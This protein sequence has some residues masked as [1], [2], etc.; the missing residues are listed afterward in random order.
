MR[1][2]TLKHLTMTSVSEN[3]IVSSFFFSYNI[4]YDTV[5][6]KTYAASQWQI[7]N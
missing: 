7:F 1:N 6:I 5:A 2:L 3:D 4:H